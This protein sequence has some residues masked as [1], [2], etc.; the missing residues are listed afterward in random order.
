MIPVSPHSFPLLALR[1]GDHVQGEAEAKVTLVEYGC[2]CCP[3]CVPLHS[4][5]LKLQTQFATQLRLVYRHFPKPDPTQQAL[6]AAEAAEAANAQGQFWKMHEHLLTHQNA[7][8]D[9]ELVEYAIALRLDISQFLWEMRQDV[10]VDRVSFDL[11][12]GIQLGIKQ[13]PALFINGHRY[14]AAMEFEALSAAIE[15]VILGRA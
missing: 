3:A 14:S 11:E 5:L 4:T 8:G 1:P 2:Y 13:V 6:H 10:Y 7:L 12:S 15:Q 9:G